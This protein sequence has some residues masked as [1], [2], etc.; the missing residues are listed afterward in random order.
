VRDW[1]PIPMLYGALSRLTGSPVVEL[2]RA[3]AIGETPGPEAA[4]AILDALELDDCRYLH[5]TRAALLRQLGRDDE[6]RLAYQR[7][8]ELTD[9]G[10]EHRFLAMRLSELSPSD[11]DE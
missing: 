2:N 6:A 3:V 4:L 8:L 11:R 7:A 5:S 1:A 10:P 9:A